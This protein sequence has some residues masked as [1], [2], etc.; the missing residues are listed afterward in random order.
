MRLD[1]DHEMVGRIFGKRLPPTLEQ[2]GAHDRKQQQ[3][4]QSQPEGDHLYGAGAAAP[5]DIG[6]SVA[7]RD[8]NPGAIPGHHVHE[9]AADEIQRRRDDDNAAE[10]DREHARV[11]NRAIDERRDGRQRQACDQQPRRCGR[12]GVV[13]QHP[14]WRSFTQLNQRRQRKPDQQDECAAAG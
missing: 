1:V 6:K 2:V 8:A 12:H 9:P 10:Q 13:A 5:R 11:S 7:P 14:E 4:G 3:H